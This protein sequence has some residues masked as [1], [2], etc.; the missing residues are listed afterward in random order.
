MLV[1]APVFAVR[2]M[3]ALA[4]GAFFVDGMI[5][6]RVSPGLGPLPAI[7]ARSGMSAAG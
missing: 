7:G 5:P 4:F 1:C 6:A 2:P 3:P